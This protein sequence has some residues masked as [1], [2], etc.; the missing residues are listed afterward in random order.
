MH[1]YTSARSSVSASISS[2]WILEKS[3]NCLSISTWNRRLQTIRFFC[4]HLKFECCIDLLNVRSKTCWN[5][6]KKKWRESK[7]TRKYLR[8]CVFSSKSKKR[9]NRNKKKSIN[10]S[11][12]SSRTNRFAVKRRNSHSRTRIHR[13][14]LLLQQQRVEYNPT[15]MHAHI[16][17]LL[18]CRIG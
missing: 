16:S 3:C 5:L 9:N 2:C 17:T 12:L 7:R 11:L 6:L 10:A 18:A 14:Q 13:F 8:I 4:T 1:L 15:G